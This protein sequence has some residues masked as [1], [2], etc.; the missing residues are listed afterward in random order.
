[1]R[2]KKYLEEKYLEEKKDKV[3]SMSDDELIGFYRKH[4]KA[5]FQGM[6]G[7]LFTSLIDEIKLRKLV[8]RI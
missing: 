1:M 3:E 2:L 5:N 8:K 7:N 4:K 6:S